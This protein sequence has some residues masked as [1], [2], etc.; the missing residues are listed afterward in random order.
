MEYRNFTTVRDLAAYVVDRLKMSDADVRAAFGGREGL[1]RAINEHR[2]SRF[3]EIDSAEL[4]QVC[5]AIWHDAFGAQTDYDRAE[6]G[7]W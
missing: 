4:D 3:A 2:S 7:G 6:G 1:H 5:R